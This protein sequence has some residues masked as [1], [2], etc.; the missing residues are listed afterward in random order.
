[1]RVPVLVVG[2]VLLASV[3]HAASSPTVVA[4][5]AV[6]G[7]IQPCAAAA[8]G[9]FVWVSAYA[10]PVLLK[11]DPRRNVVVGRTPIG[12]G[13][14]GLGYGA[15]SLWVEDTQ[16]STISR[17]SV[18]TAK[19]TAAIPVGSTPYDAMFAYGHAWASSFGSGE[20]S[21][22]SPARNSV[23]RR[24]RLQ[25]AAGIVAGF[26]SVWAVGFD[27][28]IRI[29][30]ASGAVTARIR[31]GGIWTAASVDAVWVTSRGGVARIDPATNAVAATIPLPGNLGDPAIVDG[32]LWVPLVQQNRVAI[33]DPATNAVVGSVKVGPGP[34]V[35]TEIRGEAWI[36]SWRGNAIWRLRP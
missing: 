35:V 8:G 6:P 19:R 2:I 31:Q 18:R 22:I 7:S 23:V 36:T 30:P 34:F 21:Q 4:K 13:S 28:T 17:V 32:R 10:S 20:V 24:I 26:G 9:R 14:C 29:D 27:E 15:G 16:S 3:A 1:M 12:F 5:I 11:V 33:I 25:R